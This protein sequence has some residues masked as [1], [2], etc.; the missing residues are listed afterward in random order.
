VH[1]DNPALSLPGQL[2]ARIASTAVALCWQPFDLKVATP[3][4]IALNPHPAA[5]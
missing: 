5:L 1:V 3:A 2:P 4:A